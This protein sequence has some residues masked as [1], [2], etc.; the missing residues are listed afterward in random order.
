MFQGC[1]LEPAQLLAGL[2]YIWATVADAFGWPRLDQN[3]AISL[4]E[5]LIETSELC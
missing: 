1:S 5:I 4:K 2:A 3:L